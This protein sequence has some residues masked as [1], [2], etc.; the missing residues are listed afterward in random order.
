MLALYRSEKARYACTLND[1][2]VL[3]CARIL[4]EFPAFRNRIEGEQVWEVEN[5][6]IGIAVGME[7]GLR[8]PVLVGAHRMSLK[9]VAEESHRII[10]A[11]QRGKLEGVGQGIFTI[12]NLGMF[13]IEEFAAIINPPEAAILAVGKMVDTPVRSGDGFEFRPMIQLTACADHRIVDGAGVAR[14]LADLK[15]SLE[16]PY[17]LI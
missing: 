10:E 16:N 17:L 8:V 3:A 6:G 11:A 1:V 13:G 9:Q 5:G 12:S 15:A 7:D 14:F 4:Q 2:M